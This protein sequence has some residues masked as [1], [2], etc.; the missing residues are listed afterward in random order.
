M[1]PSP[2]PLRVPLALVLALA[3]AL[4]LLPSSALAQEPAPSVPMPAA[5][6]SSI[7]L[8]GQLSLQSSARFET[9]VQPFFSLR[10]IPEL[11]FT[12][13]PSASGSSSSGA[14]RGVTVDAEASANAYGSSLFLPGQPA[15]LSGDVKPYRAWVRLSTSRFEARVGLQKVSFGSATVFRPMMWFDTLDPRD[16]LQLTDGVYALLLRFYTKGNANFWAWT[17]YGNGSR[18]GFDL[19]PSDKKTPEFGGR[20]QVPLFKGELAATYHHRKAAIDGLVPVMDPLN[21]LPVDPVPEDRFGL[22]GKWDIGVGLWLEGAL[23]HQRTPLLPLPYQLSL[24]AGLDY[25]FALGR[26]LNILAEHFRLESS[27]RAFAAGQSQN[28]SATFVRYP[29]GLSDDLTAI[30]YYDWKGRNFYRFLSW[31][32]T[33][34]ALT[35]TALVFWNP[36]TQLIF[37]GQAGSSSFAGTGLQLVL[38]YY[39]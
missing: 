36:E 37:P 33:S 32:R 15:D 4:A 22:D 21:P 10:V 8:G 25:T 6:A 20:V 34:D 12:L 7:S 29:L 16:P 2:P 5:A 39:F 18:R 17:M 24:T 28:I 30:V 31:R 1:K 23:V 26:G 38:A 13:A 27:P 14:S 9:R 11:K 35:F 3:S 19:A